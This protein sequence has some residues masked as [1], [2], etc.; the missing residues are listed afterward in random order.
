ML[1]FMGG[2]VNSEGLVVLSLMIYAAMF[3][4]FSIKLW[5]GGCNE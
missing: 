4:I 1:S 3:D 5:I 2:E